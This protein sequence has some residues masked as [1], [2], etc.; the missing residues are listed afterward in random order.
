[1]VYVA[2]CF[3]LAALAGLLFFAYALC[4]A[5]ARADEMEEWTQLFM[6]EEEGSDEDDEVR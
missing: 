5:A 3:G 6:P 4:A 1:M 2:V